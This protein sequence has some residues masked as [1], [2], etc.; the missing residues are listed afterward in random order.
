MNID[1]DRIDLALGAILHE[2]EWLSANDLK[3]QIK[4]KMDAGDMKIAL[5]AGLLEELNAVMESSQVL[6]TKIVI[7]KEQCEKLT[8][9]GGEDLDECV[10]K[11]VIAFVEDESPPMAV[12]EVEFVASPPPQSEAKSG[13]AATAAKVKKTVINC[14]KCNA[15]IEIDM[16]DMPSE[17]KCSN[18]NARGVLKTSKNKPDF[19]D[20]YLG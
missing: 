1:A 6:E 8:L 11:A 10:R 16:E 18:C 17:V 5:L 2:N 4:S 20:H 15:P 7:S 12:P 9:L 13:Q 3:E 14:S 19:N